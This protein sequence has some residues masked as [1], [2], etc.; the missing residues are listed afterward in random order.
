MKQS[1]RSRI[2]FSKILIFVTIFTLFNI[3]DSR[4]Y[5]ATL[6]SA[7]YECSTTVSG[8]TTVQDG[9][10]YGGLSYG[11]LLRTRIKYDLSSLGSGTVTSA[12]LNISINDIT[13]DTQNPT[14]EVVGSTQ[15]NF[16]SYTTSLLPVGSALDSEFIPSTGNYSFDVTSFINQELNGDGTATLVLKATDAIEGNSANGSY[17]SAAGFN[18]AS[19]SLDVTVASLSSDATLSNLVP[20]TGA[21]SPSFDSNTTSYTIN[22]DNSIDSINFTPTAND[23][24]YSALTV[25]G[26]NTTSGNASANT[27]LSVGD[28]VINIV[29][30]AEDGST[31]KTY[32]VTVNRA[33]AST[34]ATL[35]TLVPN[36]GSLSPTF[37]SNTTSY[38]INLPYSNTT[39]NFT[40]TANDSNYTSVTVDGNNTTSGFAS[41]NTSLSVGDNVIDIIVTAEDG[42]TQKTYAVT[43][44]RAALSTDA[45]LS[46]LVPNYGSLSPSFDS[47]TT[48]YS[49]NLPYSNTTINFTPTANDS[50][51]SALTVDGNN[52]TSGFAS[53]NIS[54]SVGNN[55]IDIVV[56]A[57]DGST[58]KTY[59]ITINRQSAP[60]PTPD[61]QPDPD[62]GKDIEVDVIVDDEDDGTDN[63]TA[64]KV[65]INRKEEDGKIKDNIE[66][67]KTKADETVKKL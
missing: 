55:N 2:I 21:L 67:D 38:S 6:N 47:S 43:V 25:D 58:Q 52:T 9:Y 29:V 24:S 31:Q 56:T 39:I 61:P 48:N 62:D 60:I 23:S 8:S 51:Y 41:A 63:Q 34:D 5:A 64:A 65:V 37:D 33:A 20:S 3:H 26:N 7:T 18:T 28:N 54:L 4:A 22:L 57:E 19:F 10:F 59:T 46:N 16:S 30:T 49:I 32:T 42:S 27:S 44:N 66:F 45:T 50:S 35:S 40:P 53:S 36:Y 17:D 14:I 11:S 1:K 12:T 13:N 15:D